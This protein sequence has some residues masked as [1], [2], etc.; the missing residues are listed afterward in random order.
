MGTSPHGAN[1]LTRD[2]L[3]TDIGGRRFDSYVRADIQK[4]RILEQREDDDTYTKYPINRYSEGEDVDA[5]PM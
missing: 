5:E 2:G 3:K 4:R 1:C